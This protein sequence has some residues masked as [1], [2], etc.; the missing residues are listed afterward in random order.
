MQ[1][2]FKYYAGEKHTDFAD[3]AKM[4]MIKNKYAD[5]IQIKQS[6]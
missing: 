3:K 6:G 1:N 5:E 4:N 2:S